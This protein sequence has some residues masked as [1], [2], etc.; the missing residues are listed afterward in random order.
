MR[1]PEKV[2]LANLPTP[3]HRLD[4][5]SAAFGVEAFAK[6]DDM[7]G[8][9]ESGNKIRKL[10]YVVRDLLDR[11][12]DT[13]VTCG[14]A[15]SNHA[16]AGALAAARLGLR[17]TLILRRPP[18]GLVG[19]LFLDRLAGADIRFVEPETYYEDFDRVREEVMSGLAASGRKPYWVPTGAS[20]PL[21]AVGYAGCAAEI[22]DHVRKTGSPFDVI[23][24]ATGSG[25]T[26]AGLLVGVRASGLDA[27]VVGVNTGEPT[28]R[29]RA[30]TLS[31]AR[32]CADL[33]G[34]DMR[35]TAEDVVIV[36]GYD[37]GGY[38]MA[39]EA[40]FGTIR[41]FAAEEGLILDPVYTAKAASGLVGMLERGEI[42]RGERVLFV[43][44]GG[45]FGLFAHHSELDGTAP[46][47]R[48]N[49][50]DESV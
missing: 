11:G 18:P 23:L 3:V 36:D 20:M 46:K 28:G 31:I 34:V 40:V 37:A 33:L 12:C 32:G 5:L 16:R 48:G 43:H 25:G 45:V 24:F 42:K 21:G 38:G 8:G 22:A 29:L 35:L 44:T 1:F 26:A 6:R 7:T 4:R 2:R 15:D 13:L 14:G 47:R 9:A 50:I 27:R 49:G 30:E 10:E 19:N 41:R 39:D 17:C